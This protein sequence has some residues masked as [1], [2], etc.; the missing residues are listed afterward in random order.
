MP[1]L[2]RHHR[3]RHWID[4]MCIFKMFTIRIDLLV[5]PFIHLQC[6]LHVV[7]GFMDTSENTF[8]IIWMPRLEWMWYDVEC[9]PRW[10]WHVMQEETHFIM[11]CSNSWSPFAVILQG[12]IQ[13][14]SHRNGYL[15]KNSFILFTRNTLRGARPLWLNCFHQLR[16]IIKLK[17]QRSHPPHP[18]YL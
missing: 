2:R 14:E 8:L 9:V 18:L 1:T 4:M 15:K 10:Y 13:N 12:Q 5:H 16:M 6:N 17:E 7:K 11:H 3:R